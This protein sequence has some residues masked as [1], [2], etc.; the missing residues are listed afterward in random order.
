[1]PKTTALPTREQILAEAEVANAR[2]AEVRQQMQQ[3][4]QAEHARRF[5]A[6]RQFDD[7]LVAGYSREQVEAEVKQAKATLDQALADNPLVLALAD[8]L[9]ALRRRSHAVQ[10]H[11]S[12]LGR[13]GRPTAPPMAGPTE[14]AAIETYVLSAAERLASDRISTELADLHARRD[15]AGT[16]TTEETAA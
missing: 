15:A 1:M 7:Q 9:T 8:Y 2:A 16:T 12:A 13:L 5:E 6:Q 3:E 4:Q 11:M 10:E 14:L